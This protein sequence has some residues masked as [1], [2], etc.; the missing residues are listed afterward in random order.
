MSNKI[1]KDSK[2]IITFVLLVTL[3]LIYLIM[4]GSYA[5]YKKQVTADS[6]FDIAKWNIEVNNEDITNKTALNNYIIPSFESNE[7]TKDSVI[8]PGSTG[9]CDIIINPSNVDV[10]FKYELTSSIP[11]ESDVKD[12]KITSYIIDPTDTNTTPITFIQGSSITETIEHNSSNKVIRIY[13]KWDDSENSIMNNE[14]DTNV[15]TNKNAKALISINLS[16]SQVN[17]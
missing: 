5:K 1:S 4:Q 11:E 12:L 10:N 8:A 7:N 17:E 9:Y 14:E 13:I 2:F 6:N 3:C 15:A 16:F